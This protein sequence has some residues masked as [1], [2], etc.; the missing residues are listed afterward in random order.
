MNFLRG[1]VSIK[2]WKNL[3][4]AQSFSEAISWQI[5]NILFLERG[6]NPVNGYVEF[7][8]FQYIKTMK[9]KM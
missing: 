7:F 1:T 5:K 2:L 8:C 3:Y 6:Y 4:N 9:L